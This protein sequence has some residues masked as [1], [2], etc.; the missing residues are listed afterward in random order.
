MVILGKGAGF[1]MIDAWFAAASLART[2]TGFAIG[3]SVYWAP[4]AQHLAG[5]IDSAAAAARIAENY[6]R[7]I[8]SWTNAQTARTA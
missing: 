5:T 8:Q 1:E 2:A 4:A 6:L 7:V 3:R